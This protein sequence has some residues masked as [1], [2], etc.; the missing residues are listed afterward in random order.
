[1]LATGAAAILAAPREL[2]GDSD[3]PVM[4]TAD[5]PEN[6]RQTTQ[7]LLTTTRHPRDTTRAGAGNDDKTGARRGGCRGRSR[8]RHRLSL[9]TH[10]FKFGAR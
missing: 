4:P 8:A 7:E 1:M 10:K 9:L 3:S 2:A 6:L 5:N